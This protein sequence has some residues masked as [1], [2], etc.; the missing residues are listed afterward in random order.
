MLALGSQ[1]FE[2]LREMFDR[3]AVEY[4]QSACLDKNNPTETPEHY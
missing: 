3:H 4:P 1:I 2:L